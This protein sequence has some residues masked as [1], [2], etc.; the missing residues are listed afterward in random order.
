MKIMFAGIRLTHVGV[1]GLAAALFS[2]A[3]ISAW[4]QVL[5]SGPIRVIVP[6]PPA[7]GTDTMARALAQRMQVNLGQPVVVENRPGANGMIGIQAVVGAPPDGL[8]LL[9]TPNS[10]IVAGPHMYPV[11]YDVRKDL[12]PVALVANGT[13]VLVA[14]PRL[15]FKTLDEMVAYAKQNPGKLSF[16]SAGAGSQAHLNLEILSSA[17]GIK[18]LHVPY[19]GGGPAAVDLVGGHVDLFFESLP[20]M[21]PHIR[22]GA[23]VA[24]GVTSPQRSPFLPNVPAI[25]ETV[26][27]FDTELTNPWYGSFAPAATPEPILTRL[28]TELHKVIRDPEVQR[29]LPEGGFVVAPPLPPFE[30]A[31][32]LR[33]NYDR[34]GRMIKSLN[35]NV[36]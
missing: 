34:F 2:L 13:F 14:H 5:P 19:K 7:A 9:F 21:L 15:P 27:D 24:L 18:V 22:S 32:F 3:S 30:F 16:A 11:T 36:Q 6:Y 23:M 35:I 17:A 29:S 1:V 31:A 8:T 28:N 26:K 25:V 20:I 4:T 33:I 12:A 10:P